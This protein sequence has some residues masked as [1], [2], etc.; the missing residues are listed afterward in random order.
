MHGGKANI[1]LAKEERE[2]ARKFKEMDNCLYG[3]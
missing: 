2:T 1:Y 3:I